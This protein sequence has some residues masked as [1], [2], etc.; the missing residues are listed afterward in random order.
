MTKHIKNP[1]MWNTTTLEVIENDV[2]FKQEYEEV[3]KT[4]DDAFMNYLRSECCD[5]IDARNKALDTWLSIRKT[6]AI[7]KLKELPDNILTL[8]IYLDF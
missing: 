6:Q 8:E 3:T 2:F 1:E 4:T 5:D 7:I